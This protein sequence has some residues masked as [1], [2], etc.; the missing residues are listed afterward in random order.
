MSSDIISKQCKKVS[1]IGNLPNPIQN[2]IQAYTDVKVAINSTIVE[3]VE[4]KPLIAT[5]YWE[6]IKLRIDEISK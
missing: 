2:G 6:E 4:I 5:A 1:K 3:L